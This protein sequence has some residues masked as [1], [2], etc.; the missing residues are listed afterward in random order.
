MSG[1]RAVGEK[2]DRMS[3]EASIENLEKHTVV[4][5]A[6][7]DGLYR[8]ETG[9]DVKEREWFFVHKSSAVTGLMRLSLRKPGA[10]SLSQTCRVEEW[11]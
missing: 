5:G 2:A 1:Q 4:G 6:R 8:V 3:H 7:Q 11:S 10:G 9:G